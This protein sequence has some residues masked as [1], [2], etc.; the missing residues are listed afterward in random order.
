MPEN[1]HKKIGEVTQTA[2]S[3]AIHA[4]V[5]TMKDVPGEEAANGLHK[6]AVAI[7]GGLGG[8]AAHINNYH[9]A[10]HSGYRKK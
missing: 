6:I 2:L 8:G 5:F 3:K 4:A 10:I 7:T 1:W 9:V